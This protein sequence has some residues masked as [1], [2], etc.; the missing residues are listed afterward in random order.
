MIAAAKRVWDRM[1]DLNLALI[2]AGVGFFSVLALFPALGLSVLLWSFFA[3]PAS[4]RALLDSAQGF[5]PNQVHAIFA[6]QVNSLITASSGSVFGW[7]TLLTVGFAAWSV[8]SGISSLTRGINTAYG[9]EHRNKTTRRILSSAG[10]AFALCGPILAAIAVTVVAPLVLAHIDLGPATETAIALLRWG[11]ALCVITF[12]FALIYRFAPNRRGRRP[13][14]LTPGALIGGVVWLV[15]SVGFSVYLGSF[16]NYNKVYGSLGAAVVLF[17]WFYLS[18]Y[19]V[20]IGAAF[21]A[22]L[23]RVRSGASP[24]E[25]QD[26]REPSADLSVSSTLSQDARAPRGAVSA[27]PATPRRHDDDSE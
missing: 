27:R 13:G 17:M 1:D 19:V 11:V 16:G 6:Q 14:W 21:N 18:A 2:A 23:E 20:L 4:I 5:M 8:L 12:A 9:V 22:Q 7:A 3:D 15:M 24:T 10:L 26:A 25:T